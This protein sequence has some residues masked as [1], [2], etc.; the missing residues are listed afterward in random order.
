MNY[1]LKTYKRRPDMLAPSE[2]KEIHP[3]GKLPIVSVQA[4]EESKPL[5]LAESGLIIEY[6]VDHFG[7]WLVPKKY[8]EGQEDQVGGET[9]EWLRYRY[10]MHYAEGSLMILM[11]VVLILS[12]IVI[13]ATILTHTLIPR[14]GLENNSPFF[15]KPIAKAIV[16]GIYAKYLTPNFE[17]HLGFLESQLTTSPKGGE[18]L[19][20]PELTGADI[21]MSFPLQAAKGRAGLKKETYPKLW[22][23]VEKC[24]EREAYKRA[25]QKVVDVEGSYQS[26]L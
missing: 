1:D 11:V 9:E 2:L 19:C 7:P 25:V 17:T 18:F 16:S 6:L 22:A 15:I 23:Y 8:P 4:D 13:P 24:Q 26:M 20:G 3:L 5:I 21:Q 14:A 10:Y 12:S